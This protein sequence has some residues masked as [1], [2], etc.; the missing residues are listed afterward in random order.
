MDQWYRSRSRNLWVAGSNLRESVW[1][2]GIL[3]VW[4]LYIYGKRETKNQSVNVLSWSSFCPSKTDKWTDRHARNC[5][6][7]IV[8]R[9]IEYFFPQIEKIEDEHENN[10]TPHWMGEWLSVGVLSRLQQ[11]SQLSPGHMDCVIWPVEG[12]ILN[13]INSF[14]QIIY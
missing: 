3:G 9:S 6:L 1:I 7:L 2:L 12:E 10:S 5:N 13:W 8:S 14:L 11:E 4:I